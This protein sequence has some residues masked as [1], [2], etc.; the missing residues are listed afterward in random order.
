MDMTGEQ[1]LD[2]PQDLVWR[3]LNDPEMLRNSIPG[4]Q[5]LEKAGEN[6]FEATVKAKVG[7]VSAKFSGVVE[8]SDIEAPNSY[9]ISGQGKGGVAGY[10]S[11]H[12][13][14]T[15]SADGEGT[16][17][18]YSVN[19]KVGGKLAQIGSRLIDS[20]AKKMAN[21]FFANFSENLT[22]YSRG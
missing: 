8:L 19:A 20:S 3:A 1:K 2:A 9:R 11:G 17:L 12:A 18:T 14:V 7:P 22:A 15:L 6:G 5:A 10:A 13:D 16:L 21:Q 4:C